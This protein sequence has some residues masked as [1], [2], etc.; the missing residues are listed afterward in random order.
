[1]VNSCRSS[2]TRGDVFRRVLS[3]AVKASKINVDTVVAAAA[4]AVADV[5]R[6]QR[7]WNVL[8]IPT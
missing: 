5:L 4:A 2:R 3:V 8:T 1:M 6:E 7:D